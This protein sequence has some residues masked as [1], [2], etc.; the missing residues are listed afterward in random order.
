MKL[1]PASKVQMFRRFMCIRFRNSGAS[2]SFRLFF[3]SISIVTIFLSTLAGQELLK[4]NALDANT[5]WGQVTD[6]GT[7]QPIQNATIAV[8]EYSTVRREVV[9]VLKTITNTG[10]NGSYRI[11]FE[12][13]I[14]G[15]VQHS[16]GPCVCLRP[17][18]LRTPAQRR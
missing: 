2:N 8:W 7:G 9:Y 15:R 12:E 4:A 5:L 6:A 17:G 1:Q 18:L 14:R 10:V 11:S 3:L 16:E 13:G